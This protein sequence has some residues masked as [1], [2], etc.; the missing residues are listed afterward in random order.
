M[1][2][3]YA[4]VYWTL[5]VNW[6]DF[7][8]LPVEDIDAAAAASKTIRYQRECVRRYVRDEGGEL[9]AEIA[10]M[11]TRTDRATD[12]VRDVL[13]RKAPTRLGA[14]TLLAVAFEENHHWRPNPFLKIA[15]DELGLQLIRLSPDPITLDGELFDP[16]RHFATWRD[17]DVRAMEQLRLAAQEGMQAA[18][19]EVPD[20]AGRWAKIA[21]LLNS[22]GVKTVRG[23]QWTA[24]N[25][26]KFV[27]RSPD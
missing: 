8:D 11:E 23:G 16:A 20:G 2:R 25:V 18:R 7:R 14:L 13:R 5:P 1:K 21:T 27:Q 26:R 10:F 4:G 19:G 15:A 12:A 6:A 3:L 17:Q 24:E 9:A 22:R